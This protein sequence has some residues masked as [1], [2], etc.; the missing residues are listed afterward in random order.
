MYARVCTSHGI[1]SP[2]CPD[3]VH[4]TLMYIVMKIFI[5]SH[6]YNPPHSFSHIPADNMKI[7]RVCEYFDLFT[8]I[9]LP[10]AP[11]IQC[12][13]RRRASKQRSPNVPHSMSVTLHLLSVSL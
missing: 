6:A 9:P 8:P 7:V 12:W 3:R 5:C 2:A 11:P 4:H 10:Y 1:R 13:Q